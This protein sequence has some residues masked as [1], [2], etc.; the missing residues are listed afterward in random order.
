MNTRR[1]Q[2]GIQAARERHVPIV[3]DELSQD[4]QGVESDLLLVSQQRPYS[5]QHVTRH[6]SVNSRCKRLGVRETVFG[7]ITEL[8]EQKRQRVASNSERGRLA[9]R[10]VASA[11]LHHAGDDDVNECFRRCDDCTGMATAALKNR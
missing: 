3:R 8:A 11:H 5:R 4:P 10:T 2:N 1:K 9:V 6:K 7:C